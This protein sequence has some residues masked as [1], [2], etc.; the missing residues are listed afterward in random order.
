MGAPV[1][2]IEK[3]PAGC[4]SL[5]A[6]GLS[7]AIYKNKELLNVED[8]RKDL[9]CEYIDYMAVPCIENELYKDYAVMTPEIGGLNSTE[10][11]AVSAELGIYCVDCD[12]MGRAFPELQ[13]ST[14]SLTYTVLI[15][16]IL[17]IL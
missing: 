15:S 10:A 3:L 11:L 12:E 16:T 2:Q 5:N 6:I 9:G 8:I 4:E 7:Y 13:A 14:V 1:I 17:T